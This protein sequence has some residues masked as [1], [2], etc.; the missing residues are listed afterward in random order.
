MIGISG[1]VC[2]GCEQPDF[3]KIF[4]TSFLFKLE[5]YKHIISS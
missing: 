3:Q 4:L 5:H 1:N 2:G